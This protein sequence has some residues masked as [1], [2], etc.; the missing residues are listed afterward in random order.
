MTLPANHQPVEAA[1]TERD[2]LLNGIFTTAL[3][4]GIGYWS[5]AERYHWSVN[6]KGETEARDFIAV[7]HETEEDD[8]EALVIDKGIIAAGIRLATER[9]HYNAYVTKALADINARKYDEVD[10]DA[11]VA[12]IIVQWG[13]FDEVRYG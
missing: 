5:A 8:S 9:G 12:D 6:G 1:T 13:L 4:G 11:D 7:I 10:Y 3:E 2:L